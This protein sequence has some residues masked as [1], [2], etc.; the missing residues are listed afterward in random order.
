MTQ[1]VWCKNDE[2]RIPA[3]RCIL[4]RHDCYEL[5][6]RTR[7]GEVS[8]AFEML[9]NSGRFK[10][11]FVM[12]RKENSEA[13]RNQ[14][15]FFEREKK[16]T[17]ETL[18]DNN[19]SQND[20]GNVFLLE[21]GRIKPFAR[22]Q[23][24]ASILYQA[25]ESFSVECRLVRP[26]EPGN[27]VFDGKKPSKKTVPIIIKKSGECVLLDSWEALESEPSQLAE[28]HD[29]VGAMPVK[30]VFVLKRK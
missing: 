5:R 10:E 19:N 2:C 7:E 15:S 29:V 13:L 21:E 27:M 18:E 26:E 16:E 3:F 14:L 30:Q 8:Q 11:Y 25:V 20:N 17:M 4:C 22:E 23:Y 6:G 24:T 9:R 12:K 28:A 1:Y